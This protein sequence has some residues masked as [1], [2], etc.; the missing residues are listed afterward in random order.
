MKWK[1]RFSDAPSAVDRERF[2][3]NVLLLENKTALVGDA[4]IVEYIG[5]RVRDYRD[6]D[7]IKD[8]LGIAYAVKLYPKKGSP[9]SAID[10]IATGLAQTFSSIQSVARQTNMWSAVKVDPD[11]FVA[12]NYSQI[13]EELLQWPS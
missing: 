1:F 6:I 12:D 7:L 3:V 8:H 13:S 9:R 4:E 10:A 11:E 5:N 2:E